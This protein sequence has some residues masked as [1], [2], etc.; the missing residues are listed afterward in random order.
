LPDLEEAPADPD[1]LLPEIPRP[2]EEVPSVIGP[3]FLLKDVRFEG[4]TVFTA[5][6]LKDVAEP[7]IGRL[8]A[9]EDLESLR[10]TL[11]EHYVNAGYINSGAVL[12]D[13]R[14][15]EGVVNYVIVE[16]RLTEIEA[17]GLERLSADY[18]IS[19][20]RLSAGPPLNINDLQRRLRILLDDPLIARID[21]ELLP[22][23]RPGESR[24]VVQVEEVDPFG[25]AVFADNALQ[26]SVGGKQ[27]G[28]VLSI[29][30]IAGFKEIVTVQPS[31][32]EGFMEIETRAEVP[33]TKWDTRF[34]LRVLYSESEV[35]EN[36]FDA[37]DIE[38]ETYELGL[39][40]RQPL[41][42]EPGQTLTAGLGFDYRVN[43]TYLL[44]NR[45]SFSEG[46]EN[47]RSKVSVFRGTLD[48]LDR[49]QD[50][51]LAF[52]SIASQGVGLFDATTHSG[53]TP[54]S[55]F[56]SWLGQAQWVQRI[57]ESDTRLVLR[58]EG[59]WTDDRLLS[60]EKFGVGGLD[61]VRGYREDFLLGDKGWNG[62]VEL[63]IPVLDIPL[64]FVSS[65]QADG[66][67]ELI[68]FI[69]A[70]RAWDNEGPRP[71]TLAS[72]G[73]GLG[74]AI[75]QNIQANLYYGYAVQDFPDPEDEDLQDHGIHFSITARLY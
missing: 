50:H 26:P 35:V 14:V 22:G 63:H 56:F 47:G 13:Q 25:L 52:S 57:D 65:E 19:R 51:V 64:P 69:D 8:V 1:L 7:I 72:V 53:S 2:P 28:S 30:N 43:T 32:A 54:D 37:L 70:G 48:W 41:Y 68:P 16:G 38:S 31:L 17:E 46:V 5:A 9:A 58:G 67:V 66:R 15:P 11:T 12:P 49:S 10:R 6:E 42:R 55:R 40:V 33:I 45:F 75:T 24:L 74:W 18:L 36:P 34:D 27:I 71:D 60:L 29:R 44:G 59:Q 62:S 21:A 61:S 3:K 39:F 20:I 73:I 4:N 23:L